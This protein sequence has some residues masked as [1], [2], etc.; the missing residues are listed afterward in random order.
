MIGPQSV[1]KGSPQAI[2]DETE[3]R[4]LLVDFCKTNS[5]IVANT[6]FKHPPG[7]Q[8]TYKEPH[9]KVLNDDNSP[10]TVIGAR[11][12]LRNSTFV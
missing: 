9:T 12:I 1:W 4:F 2:G 5:L 6:W 7:K 3:N 10:I 11:R 8:V